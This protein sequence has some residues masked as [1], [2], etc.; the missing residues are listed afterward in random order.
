M[1]LRRALASSLAAIGLTCAAL[2]VPT[3]TAHAAP[4]DCEGGRNGFIDISDNATGTPIRTLDMG[5]GV[6]IT[7]QYGNISGSQRGWA[8]ISGRA[9]SGDRVWMDWT[10]NGGS[11]WLQC[12]PFTVGTTGTSKTSAAKTTSTSSS[13]KFR[14]CGNLNGGPVRCTTWW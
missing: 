14:A 6:S 11:S 3:A 13:Y 9:F 2:L 1:T 12:G 5:S 8:K 4:Q 10:T 7:L